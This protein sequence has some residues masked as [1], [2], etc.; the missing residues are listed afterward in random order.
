MGYAF[1]EDKEQR[2]QQQFK[3]PSKGIRFPPAKVILP[4]VIPF[5]NQPLKAMCVYH[6]GPTTCNAALIFQQT[7][8]SNQSIES[9]GPWVV[10]CSGWVG[11]P[12]HRARCPF[13]P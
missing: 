12:T 9:M 3:N 6:V 5:Q 7:E 10:G 8:T 2:H 1:V 11:D 13:R 4:Y